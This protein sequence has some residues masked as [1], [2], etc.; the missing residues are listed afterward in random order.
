MLDNDG[1]P[2]V[3]SEWSFAMGSQMKRR[4]YTFANLLEPKSHYDIQ[5]SEEGAGLVP[6]PV[7][8]YPLIHYRRLQE[9]V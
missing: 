3:F 7:K 5:V 8:E 4:D 6:K 2:I 9:S 1:N